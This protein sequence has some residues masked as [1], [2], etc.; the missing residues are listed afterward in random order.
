M[1]ETHPEALE[2]AEVILFLKMLR[3]R[4]P[5]LSFRQT[6]LGIVSWYCLSEP[7]FGLPEHWML[8]YLYRHQKSLKTYL[9]PPFGDEVQEDILEN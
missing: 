2:Q 4:Y 3:F 6:K 8:V 7:L 1:K 5:Y 9:S